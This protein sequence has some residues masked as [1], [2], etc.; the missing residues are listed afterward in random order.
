MPLL[1]TYPEAA[2]GKF[3]VCRPDDRRDTI[4]LHTGEP[5]FEKLS[6]L[7]LEKCRPSG[8]RGAIFVDF[9]ATAPYLFHVAHI[10]VVRDADPGFPTFHA[11]E[12]LEQRLVGLRQAG[13]KL[14]E[15][16]PV[17][18]LLLLRPGGKA[19]TGTV[20]F[21]AHGEAYRLAAEEF[22][23]SQILGPAAEL[24]AMAFRERLVDTEAAL[25]R[26]YDYQESELATARKR[27]MEHVRDGQ[28]GASAELDR[29]KRQQRG[30]G[31]RREHALAE[32]RREPE[33]IRPGTV[34]II[35]TVLVQPSQEAEDIQTRD[36]EVER[37]AMDIAMAYEASRG[38][39]VRDVSTPAQARLA[40]LADYPGF[41][42][43][44]KL[45]S[46]ER[47]IEVK[48]RVGNGDI[49]LTENEWARACNLGDRYWLYAVFSCGSAAPKL[50]RVRNPFAQLI[51]KAKGSVS[52][53]SGP[54]AQC[55]EP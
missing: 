33:L 52:I 40:G 15:E 48:G 20:E 47:G 53:G 51:A 17:E 28:P 16:M 22:L 11:Q 37:I 35:A 36:A 3:T 12:T 9:S 4:F 46:E 39:V 54:I 21:L 18:Y 38:A 23:R 34:D 5:V 43:Y 24:K 49:E 55:A 30:L 10:A 31:E 13:D 8:Q 32:V 27:Q 1:E 26:A 14:M 41:D 50:Y 42:P 2:R 19:A 6:A 29:I 25:I 44:S 45:G 7:A